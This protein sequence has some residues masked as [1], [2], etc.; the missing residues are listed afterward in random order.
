MMSPITRA[1]TLLA[2]G[3][4]TL[5]MTAC[6]ASPNSLPSAL[7]VRSTA[8]I[9]HGVPPATSFTTVTATVTQILPDDNSGIPHQKFIVTEL[10]PKAGQVLEVDN[11]TKFGTK[12][13]NLTVG[14]KLTLKGV[15]WNDP[16]TSGIHWTHHANKAGDA[17]FISTPDGT[18]YQ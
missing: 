3:A 18:T 8:I 2:L 9:T 6:G 10:T 16:S 15:I 4:L 7:H 1:T 14:E 13:A 17:G 11:D 5:S 12:V